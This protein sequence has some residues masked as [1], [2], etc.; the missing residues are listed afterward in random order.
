MPNKRLGGRLV[1]ACALMCSLTCA[2]EE[3][4]IVTLTGRGDRRETAAAPWMRAAVKDQLK[5]GWF[6]RS[7]ENSQIGLLF[8]DGTQLRLNQNSELQIKSLS[9]RATFTETTVILNRGRA[10]SNARPQRQPAGITPVKMET[11]SAVLAIRGTAWE[12]EVGPE[13]Q[14]QLVVLSGVVEISNAQGRLDIGPGEA[15]R[16]EIGKAPVKFL[17]VN[18]RERVQWVTA[19]RPQPRRWVPQPPQGL[20]E[21]MRLIEAGEYQKAVE[22]LAQD[23]GTDA[24]LLRA[25]VLLATGEVSAAIEVLRPHARDGA[26]PGAAVALLARASMIS[27]RMD[28]AKALVAAGLRAQPADYELLLAAG[29]LAILEGDAAGAR[30]AFSQASAAVPQRFEAWLGLGRVE[31]ERENVALANSLLERARELA[32]AA[33]EPRAESATLATLAD[34]YER[35]A[36]LIEQLLAERPDDYLTL[37]A[38]G[39]LR[40][41]TG[42]AQEA[43]QDFLR[44][45]VIEPR[46]ARA[47][48][49]SGVA[50]YRLDDR[51]HALEAFAKAAELDARDPVPFVMRSV[52]QSDALQFGDAVADAR[53]ARE[54]MPFLRSLNQILSDQ[55]GTASL[56]SPLAA[57]GMEEWAQHLANEAYS[58]FWAGSHL[59]LADRYRGTFNK[60]TELFKGFLADPTVFGASNRQSTLIASPGHYGSVEVTA[61]TRDF[62]QASVTAT[63]NGLLASPAPIAYFVSGSAIDGKSRVND[64]TAD[65]TNL[66]IGL[67]I[68][69]RHDIG[70]FGFATDFS[71]RADLR[72]AGNGLQNG[73]LAQ[74]QSRADLGLH[75]KFSSTAQAWLK[76][77]SGRQSS[78]VSG[79]LFSPSIAN[80]LNQAFLTNIFVPLGRLD[81]FESRV[82]QDDAQFR[83]AF[84]ATDAIEVQ[85]GYEQARQE[86]PVATVVTFT[87]VSLGF[88]Q[89]HTV[90]TET[91]WIGGTARISAALA[92]QAEVHA[93]RTSSRLQ[94]RRDVTRI[95]TPPAVLLD[96]SSETL[97]ELNPRLGAKWSPSAGQTL[98][99]AG[100]RWRRPAGVNTLAPADTLGIPVNDRVVAAG[101]LYRRERLQYEWESGGNQFLVAYLDRERVRNLLTPQQAIVADL[102][103]EDLDELRN[104]RPAFGDPWDYYERTPQFGEG[105]ISSAGIAYNRLL[106]RTLTIAARYVGASTRN[107]NAAFSGLRLPYLPRHTANFGAQWRLEGR[108]ALRA[109]ATWRSDR[110]E[111]EPN[112]KPLRAGWNFG[113]GAF[114]ESDDKRWLFQ[115]KL[116][117]LHSDKE[118]SK[119]RRAIAGATLGYRF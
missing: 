77:G 73:S 102:E 8:F 71:V 69:P 80:A 112:L 90:D 24:A 83:H 28:A 110:F 1:A 78:L 65:G 103:L 75:Y 113:A 111:D 72:D 60:N 3:A 31:L 55:K 86:K 85:W 58:P 7:L 10:W 13:G 49:Y 99:V 23:P 101:G 117:N 76:A 109:I 88:A 6:V 19:Y 17:L 118:S 22:S 26:G 82:E 30:S 48:L 67:G 51:A 84:N 89:R 54:L 15:A 29:D 95:G 45:G 43:L 36:A 81:R 59:F 20:A 41:K 35:A 61:E 94:E 47:W 56:G 114:W 105:R 33:P 100:Q 32:P 37:T 25:D 96:D 74:D 107:T 92:L 46:F 108:W 64:F 9:D 21:P 4:E 27:D 57:F 12:V 62:A 106:S 2:A 52:V 11:P 104:R 91:L 97:H 40:L 16:A 5:A 79:A 63:A 50:F 53:R 18:P 98:R 44:V 14:T 116:D 115:A 42:R 66:T 34:D 70:L 87:P 93:Q 68:R 39:I 119:S 38:R